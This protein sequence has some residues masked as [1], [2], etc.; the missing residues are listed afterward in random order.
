MLTITCISP[1]QQIQSC[2]IPRRQGLH[3]PQRVVHAPKRMHSQSVLC[4]TVIS[5]KGNL[6]NLAD[7]GPNLP[8]RV[9]DLLNF[10]INLCILKLCHEV[11]PFII[12]V[13]TADFIFLSIRYEVYI[14]RQ[15][16]VVSIKWQMSN[17]DLGICISF[18]P[19]LTQ[20]LLFCKLESLCP[21]LGYP[22]I[23]FIVSG[24]DKFSTV[25]KCH[26]EIWC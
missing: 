21:C 8:L 18:K 5:I 14:K 9:M 10:N 26:L 11:H 12:Q 19:V 13:N 2:W 4:L 6:T 24:T 25:P 1:D 17:A 7:F 3:P 15:G 23:C 22:S 16:R 20:I